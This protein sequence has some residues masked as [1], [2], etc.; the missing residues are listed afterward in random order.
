MHGSSCRGA[1]AAAVFFAIIPMFALAQPAPAAD[2][3]IE[4][5]ERQIELMQK[6]LDELRLQLDEL[7]SAPAAP[8]EAAGADD[9]MAIEPVA[10]AAAPPA[11]EPLG[12]PVASS[13][14]PTSRNIFNPQIS[15]VGNVLG[16]AGDENPFDE[17]D[18]IAFDEAEIALESFVDPYAK[19]K[20]FIGVGE[21]EVE[22][23]EGFIHFLTLPAGLQAKA[24]KLKSS[25]GKFNLQHSHTWS[26]ADA[27]LVSRTFFG[28]EGLAD[29]GV[30]LSG[31]LPNPFGLYLEGTAEVFRGTVEEVFEPESRN[32]FLW[33]GHLRGYRDLSEASNL[34]MTSG[35]RSIDKDESTL[36]VAP[37][38]NGRRAHA[39]ALPLV[40]SL[41]NEEARAGRIQLGE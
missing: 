28:E 31:I 36:Q 37:D 10:T 24:G 5:L 22:L 40:R 34:G 33:V 32:D 29:A 12:A 20:I 16:H 8:A 21:D 15:V 38:E 26:W 41:G 13:T 14:A 17:R 30:S 39:Y 1:M 2:E 3:R 7:R 35:D 23:E 9:L 19:A 18:P 6:Q 11:A 4:R 27:P 25:F